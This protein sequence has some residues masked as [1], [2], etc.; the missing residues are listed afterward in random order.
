VLKLQGCKTEVNHNRVP[1]SE[2]LQ[3]G[4]SH[5]WHDLL[6]PVILL[7]LSVPHFAARSPTGL[8]CHHSVFYLNQLWAPLGLTQ[9]LARPLSAP[10]PLKA[11]DRKIKPS[12]GLMSPR[13]ETPSATLSALPYQLHNACPLLV[14]GKSARSC[15][16]SI[17]D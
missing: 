3:V 14:P 16:G 15:R 17:K 7:I 11:L 8:T 1:T 4:S 2:V 10:W 9:A 12:K 5:C 6:P 13:G